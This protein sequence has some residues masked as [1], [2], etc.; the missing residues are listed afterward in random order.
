VGRLGESAVGPR[1]IGAYETAREVLDLATGTRPG[2]RI[3]A[4]FTVFATVVSIVWIAAMQ[5][6]DAR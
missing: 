6:D 4:I 5:L 2:R 3:T 1:R